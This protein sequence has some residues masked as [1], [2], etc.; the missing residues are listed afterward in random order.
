METT[1]LLATETYAKLSGMTQQSV[2]EA[3]Q[4]GDQV[5]TR[6]VMKLMTAIA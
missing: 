4:T 6:S 5:I 1:I 3:I 2:L